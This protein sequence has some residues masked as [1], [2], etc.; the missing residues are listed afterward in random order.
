MDER[1]DSIRQGIA[2]PP[3]SAVGKEAEKRK[4]EHDATM[5]CHEVG[6]MGG[7][8]DADSAADEAAV[9]QVIHEQSGD[10]GT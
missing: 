8:S 2:V 3:E 10:R 9:N 5:P 4:Q 6:G 7:T 1:Q